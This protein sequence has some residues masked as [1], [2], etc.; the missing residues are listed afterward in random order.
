[1]MNGNILITIKLYYVLKS[2]V[3]KDF[4]IF[5]TM[6]TVAPPSIIICLSL[7]SIE[8]NKTFRE[9]VQDFTIIPAK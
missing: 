9:V 7:I 6:K 1:M 5:F 2:K 4:I 8:Y 3:F